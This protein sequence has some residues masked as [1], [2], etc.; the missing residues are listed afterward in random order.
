MPSA[1]IEQMWEELE[2]LRE[3]EILRNASSGEGEQSDP[4]STNLEN[5][6]SIMVNT[7]EVHRL[8]ENFPGLGRFF[9]TKPPRPTS[10]SS[11]GIDW[12]HPMPG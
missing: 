9:S 6:S 3:N 8:K 11:D 2:R 12:S 1:S 4:V 10:N 5:R 7:D